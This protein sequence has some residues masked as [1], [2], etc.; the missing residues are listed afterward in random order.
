[1]PRELRYIIFEPAEIAQAIAA[2]RRMVGMPLTLASIFSV[3]VIEGKDGV[4]A[5]YRVGDHAKRRASISEFSISDH[6]L[7]AAILGYCRQNG[8]PLPRRSAKRLEPFGEGLAMLVTNYQI[9]GMPDV[10]RERVHYDDPAA[11][12]VRKRAGSREPRQRP[13]R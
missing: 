9:D 8:I 6:D 5:V 11:E 2:W 1:M 12:T 3:S 10:K 13:A 4:E 7:T